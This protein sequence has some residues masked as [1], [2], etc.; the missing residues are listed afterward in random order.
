[1]VVSSPE[2]QLSG[3]PAG[4]TRIL[5]RLTAI[6]CE[7][8]PCTNDLGGYSYAGS[9]T[10]AAMNKSSRRTGTVRVR[11]GYQHIFF[12]LKEQ[13]SRC[14]VRRRTAAEERMSKGQHAMVQTKPKIVKEGRGITRGRR[15]Q[16]RHHLSA[17]LLQGAEI[18]RNSSFFT[19]TFSRRRVRTSTPMPGPA[20]TA[21]I[22]SL[23]TSKGGSTISS[24]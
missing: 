11:R 1:M 24:L 19:V 8:C 17:I 12:S 5:R 7:R 18:Q 21:I 2:G 6:S 20:G 16:N 23:S 4:K 15:P 14:L 22:P 9:L 10:D 3:H 13:H